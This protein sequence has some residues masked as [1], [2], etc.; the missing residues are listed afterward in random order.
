MRVHMC[1]RV[2]V[3]LKSC[4]RFLPAQLLHRA[5]ISDLRAILRI[6]D[7]VKDVCKTQRKNTVSQTEQWN[8]MAKRNVPAFWSVNLKANETFIWNRQLSCVSQQIFWAHFRAVNVC[9]YNSKGDLLRRRWC[10]CRHI[11]CHTHVHFYVFEQFAAN[12]LHVDPIAF[13]SLL[14][15]STEPCAMF[16]RAKTHAHT[17]KRILCWKKKIPQFRMR[18]FT[19][20]DRRH[21]FYGL[22]ACVRV[23]EHTHVAANPL[24]E[25]LR[26]VYKR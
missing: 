9:N 15:S 7:N 11:S 6:D 12:L 18:A 24:A 16:S 19:L 2:R 22:R 26:L 3:H 20:N 23:Y 4:R 8:W 14:F 1:A 21:L 13:G 5:N 25:D 10:C 17:H